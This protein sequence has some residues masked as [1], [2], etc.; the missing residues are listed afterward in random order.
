MQDSELIKKLN[1]LSDIRPDTI[2]KERNREV[3]FSQIFSG[4]SSPEQ[5]NAD[6][7][8]TNPI[9]GF[10]DVMIISR[11]TN[12]LTMPALTV[13]ILIVL[14]F[15]S[16]FYSLRAARSTKP[17]DSLYIAKI[18]SEKTQLALT[19]NE[20]SKAKLGVSFASNRTKE[21]A[22]MVND[23]G[24]DSNYKEEQVSRLT[25]DFKNEIQ[26][27]KERL[28]KLSENDA[29]A[30]KTNN[31][32]KTEVAKTDNKTADP[33]NKDSKDADGQVFSANLGK[34]NTNMEISTP[35]DKKAT[36][37]P[38]KDT[39]AKSDSVSVDMSGNSTKALLEEAEKL[40]EN[41][42]YNGTINKLEEVNTLL[43]K[44]DNEQSSIDFIKA[45]IKAT[46]TK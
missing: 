13:V 26:N 39:A 15:G 4:T 8:R 32:A 17:G 23:N 27:T 6:Y 44:S 14:V 21:L 28:N 36:V 46:T 3:L 9:I 30:Q 10:I 41:K 35:S 1:M 11:F 29:T 22:E 42:D 2:W 37:T 25:E 31:S 5:E 19:F 24:N 16:G 7:D 33:K 18:V 12:L 20:N 38:V 45:T 40:F 43:D 34:D